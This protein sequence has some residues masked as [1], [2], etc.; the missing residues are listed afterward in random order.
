MRHSRPDT[1]SGL[2][3]DFNRV[4]VQT[5]SKGDDDTRRI[6]S[7]LI[8]QPAWDGIGRDNSHWSCMFT[9]HN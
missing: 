9:G 5:G 3:N 2:P 1:L 6:D 7:I 8:Y 4:V